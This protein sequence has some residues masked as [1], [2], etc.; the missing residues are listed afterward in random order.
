MRYSGR[1]DY[2]SLGLGSGEMVSTWQNITVTCGMYNATTEVINA[3]YDN[4]SVYYRASDD[5]DSWS[6]WGT[7]TRMGDVFVLDVPENK[8]YL[9][10]KLDLYGTTDGLTP[11]VTRVDALNNIRPTISAASISAI[12]NSNLTT[13]NLTLSI[14][15]SDPENDLMKNVTTW[16]ID[17]V[18]IMPLNMPFE[19]GSDSTFTKDFSGNENNG[20]VDGATW[21]SSGGRDGMGA[22]SFDGVND[23]IEMSDPIDFDTNDFSVSLWAKMNSFANYKPMFDNRN[24][25]GAKL[26]FQL[27]TMDSGT[28]QGFFDVGASNKIVSS[29]GFNDDTWYHFVTTV[30]RD[31]NMVL[32]VDGVLNDTEDISAEVAVDMTNANN[33]FIGWDGTTSYFNGTVDDVQIYNRA[34]GAEQV[35]AIY[36]NR[37]DLIVSQVTT[38]NE[39]WKACVT[40]TD[41]GLNGNGTEVCTN[42]ILVREDVYPEVSIVYPEGTNYTTNITAMNYSFVESYPDTCWYSLNNGETNTTINCNENA[43]SL[44][45]SEGINTWSFYMNDS[46]GNENTTS[47]LFTKDTIYPEFDIYSPANYSNFTIDT[48]INY[49]TTDTNLQTCWWTND[50]GITN[51]TLTCGDNI[52]S[53]VWSEGTSTIVIYA[54]DT[55]SNENLTSVTFIKD[56]AVPALEMIYP[57]NASTYTVTNLSLNFTVS[58]VSTIPEICWY[59]NWTGQNTTISCTSNTSFMGLDCNLNNVTVY[60]NDSVNNINVSDQIF[61]SIQT[62]DETCNPTTTTSTPAAAASSGGGGGGDSSRANVGDLS[63]SEEFGGD[64]NLREGEDTNFEVH[65]ESHTMT[66]KEIKDESVLLEFRSE[67][68]EVE[69]D[70]GGKEQIDLDADGT[71]DVAV[72][73]K[74]VLEY[75]AFISLKIIEPKDVKEEKSVVKE[76]TEDE[77]GVSIV[78]SVKNVK[79]NMKGVGILLGGLLLLVIVIIVVVFRRGRIGGIKKKHMMG[80]IKEMH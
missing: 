22:Y 7:T 64:I 17:D 21:S 61:F 26:G 35:L 73:V 20:D 6:G 31:G 5:N 62:A 49:S 69:I 33:P 38:A 55:H 36:Q 19:G 74:T 57:T 3:C 27:R 23:Y 24:T 37:T 14:T 48:E 11:M 15:G 47:V 67:P 66:L 50:T 53:Q 25:T 78:E 79:L 30:D 43:T 46:S 9:Q 41:I 76:E 52:T 18:S 65:G 70:E 80:K 58:D 42:S 32:Y 12:A 56:T 16:Y 28:I 1:G 59:A 39:T 13:E 34:L 51:N 71:E 68:I 63:E 60:A 29:G 8:T 72:H 10:Y 75:T 54:N 2:I 45:S 44:S 40:P 4:V 77:E